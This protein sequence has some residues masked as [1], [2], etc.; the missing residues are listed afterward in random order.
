MTEGIR[1]GGRLAMSMCAVAALAVPAAAQVDQQRASMYFNEAAAICE[2]D[3][4]RLWGV[5]LCGPMVF[6]D[7]RTRTIATSQPPP[8]GERPASVGSVNAPIEWAGERWAAYIWDFITPLDDRRLRGEFMLHELFH[9]IQPQLGLITRNGQ[10]EHLD[11]VDG[12]YWL[13]LEWRALAQALRLAGDKGTRALR[14]ALAFRQTRRTL[15]PNAAE[16]ERLDE[17]REGL[18]QYRGTVVSATSDADAAASALDQLTAA[19]RQETFVQMFAY[20]SGVAC[21]VL[22]DTWSRGWTRRVQATSDLGV[23]L[24]TASGTQ[25]AENAAAAAAQYGG[26]ELRAAEEKRDEQRKALVRELR[27]RFVEGPVLLLPSGGGGTFDA[28]GPLQSRAT[29]RSIFRAIE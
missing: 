3:G 8:T 26:T 12:R 11:T 22:L 14:D 21:G 25:P 24:T 15:F 7:L 29:A 2:R 13:Q 10:N 4:A 16:N 17:I 5:S 23:M 9:R 18:A 6:G 1:S 19:E 28:R 27:E 20:A